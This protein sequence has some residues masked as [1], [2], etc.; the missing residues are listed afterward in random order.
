MWKSI[1]TIIFALIFLGV[2]ATGMQRL[3]DTIVTSEIDN[4]EALIAPV[5]RLQSDGLGV[6]PNS[7]QV[8]SKIQAL[9][10]WE[11]DMFTTNNTTRAVQLDLSE[12]IAGSGP[13]GGAPIVPFA[14][15]QK[16][17]ARLIAKCASY[18][19]RMQDLLNGQTVSCP[20]AV[21]FDYGGQAYRLVMNPDNFLDT[22]S[23]YVSCIRS[24]STGK[25]NQWKL[26]PSE[27][28]GDGTR[29]SIAK[30]LKLTTVKGKAVEENQGNFY[31]SFSITA[32]TP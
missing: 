16:V 8:V 17:R 21:R 13:N 22:R 12:P 29:K 20:L 6:Y 26:E 30:L 24:D 3:T 14:A 4:N 23:I 11:L 5:L 9:G 18:G 31:L 25:C 27:L 1:L 10:D 19:V 2:L 15:P 32:T 7:K 28:Q